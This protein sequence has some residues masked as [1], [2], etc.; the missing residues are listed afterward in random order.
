[1]ADKS[2]QFDW[3]VKITRTALWITLGALALA[4]LAAAVLAVVALY[5]GRFAQA[6]V[7]VGVIICAIAAAIWTVAT[8]GV[9]KVVVSNEQAVSAMADRLADIEPIFADQRDSMHALV[10]LGKLSDQAK[11]LV[12]HEVEVEAFREAIHA[13]LIRQDYR[14]AQSLL[15][16]IETKLGYAD[17]AARL[18]EEMES[19][20]K[21]SLDEKIDTAVRRVMSIIARFDWTRATRETRR[22]Q[23]LFPD[24]PKIAALVG[25][26][27]QARQK[28]KSELL[29]AYGEATRKNDVD[30]G[31]QLLTELDKYLSPQEAGAL[32]ESARG[33]FRAKLHNLGVQF[34]IRVSEQQWA[35][36][37]S[38]GEEII[39]SY[40]N[41]RMAQEVR[42]KLGQL[43]MRAAQNSP[44][45]SS[46]SGD[47][48]PTTS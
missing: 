25:H 3:V 15:E 36:A 14:S 38:V 46:P 13:D 45:A 12:Y 10:D 26:V 27:E 47:A 30:A 28:R 22:L 31:I 41:S 21:A 33:V 5:H 29:Q 23:N 35:E 18:R 39:R 1:M 24:N 32:R 20:R 43:R 6:L 48:G 19:N 2:G 16:S 8:Y 4:V 7:P 42:D 44:V 9:I 37:V 34:A 40:P 17:E 11:S